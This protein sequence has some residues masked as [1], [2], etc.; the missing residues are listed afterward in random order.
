M[1]NLREV[2]RGE[3]PSR[4]DCLYPIAPSSNSNVSLLYIEYFI[5]K[6][7]AALLA[8]GSYVIAQHK[9]QPEHMD[10][11]I[12]VALAALCSGLVS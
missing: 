3:V 12:A 2:E 8:R 7:T 1:L 10:T 6:T 9:P 4:S 11:V 5:A